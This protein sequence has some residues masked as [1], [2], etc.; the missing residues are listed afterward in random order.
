MSPLILYII[1][2]RKEKHSV[3]LHNSSYSS[4][5]MERILCYFEYKRNYTKSIE[6]D[7]KNLN[8]IIIFR[9]HLC[10]KR[11]PEEG[12]GLKLYLSNN[13]SFKLYLADLG[14][15]SVAS[16]FLRLPEIHIKSGKETK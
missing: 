10:Q 4:H 3:C 8:N 13:F 15:M 9:C 2:K 12:Q 16:L 1:Y 6:C 7:W 11:C 5:V 14:E